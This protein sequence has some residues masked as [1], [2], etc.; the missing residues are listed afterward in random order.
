MRWFRRQRGHDTAPSQGHLS[1][2][3]VAQAAHGILDSSYAASI[4]SLGEQL[5]GKVVAD[6]TGG[7]SGY[8][9]RFEDGGWV[10]VWLDPSLTQMTH[11]TG[12]GE[13][14]L[15][16]ISFLSNPE[17]ADGSEPLDVDLP[18]A[19]EAN[20]IAAEARRTH[21]KAVE[22]GRG[23]RAVVQPLLPRWSGARGQRVR[24][25]QRSLDAA[26]VLRAVVS[27]ARVV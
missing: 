23:R 10:A 24:G 5:G 2:E 15:R 7:H 14:P 16:V 27:A 20:D 19:N 3:E 22:G 25:R 6:S 11:S 17:V 13:P 26:S 4:R 8:L 21:G 9:L 18:Y 12:T 1:D